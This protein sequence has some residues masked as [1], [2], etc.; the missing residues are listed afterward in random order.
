MQRR[1]AFVFYGVHTFAQLVQN[2]RALAYWNGEHREVFIF[3]DKTFWIPL[4]EK[5]S[6]KDFSLIIMD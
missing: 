4:P 3:N 1:Y 2:D 5:I 6:K